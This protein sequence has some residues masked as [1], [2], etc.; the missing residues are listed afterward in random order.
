MVK[1]NN[2]LPNVHLHKWWQRN[3]KNA[4]HRAP[5]KAVRKRKRAEKSHAAGVA[6]IGLL[7]PIVHCCSQKH[8]MKNRA[9]RG[10]N[11]EELA[12]VGISPRHA[13]TV[14]IAVDPRRK[15]KSATTKAA[16]VARLTDYMSKVIL[17]PKKGHKS[18][19]ND[20]GLPNDATRE[21]VPATSLGGRSI[22]NVFP[23]ARYN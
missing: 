4:F 1:H 12:A 10:F 8:N 22:M 5:Q 20:G 13:P 11:L 6:P 19:K 3:V 18:V 21:S 15:A 7:R 23:I 14:G 2:A 17:L 16:N 9:G